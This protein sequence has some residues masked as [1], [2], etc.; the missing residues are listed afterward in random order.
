MTTAMTE[1]RLSEIAA[2]LGLAEKELMQEG[3]L[4]LLRERKRQA[5]QL[6]LEILARYGACSVSDLEDKIAAGQVVEHPAWE[7]LIV[8]ENLDTYL[9]GLD[10]YLANLHLLEDDRPQRIH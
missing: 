3:V 8:V 10:G 4:A 6:R 9:E 2:S 1:G 5:L 7:D